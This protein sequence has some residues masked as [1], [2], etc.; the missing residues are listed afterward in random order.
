[1]RKGYM[2]LEEKWPGWVFA[3]IGLIAGIIIGIMLSGGVAPGPE[4]SP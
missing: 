4:V 2:T 3:A 1:M